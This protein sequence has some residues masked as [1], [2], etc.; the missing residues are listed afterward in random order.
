MLGVGSQIGVLWGALTEV[1][2]ALAGI[3][4]AVVLYP[5]ARRQS[6]LAAR[7]FVTV[8]VLEAAMTFVGVVALLSIVSLRHT[9][10]TGGADPAALVT[11]GHAL[12][13][14]YNAEFLLG[15][16]LMPPISGLLL[17][18]VMYK[19][20]LVPRL[21][22]II[23]LIGAPLLLASDLAI[24]FQLYAPISPIAVLAALPIAAW[25]FSLGAWMLF[26]GFKPSS[27]L[28]VASR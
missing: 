17:G 3:G 5:V 9:A 7:G 11:T 6:E 10:T 13:A 28:M 15:Q 25:G 4:T 23:G 2:V 16:S 14:V 8:R 27:P 12:V 26:K 1:I 20:G 22:P 24:F 18:Y 19:S 21:L